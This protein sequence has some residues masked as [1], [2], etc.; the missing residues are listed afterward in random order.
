MQNSVSTRIAIAFGVLFAMGVATASAADPENA[1]P[2]DGPGRMMGSVMMGGGGA[3]MMS[4]CG[5]AHP[6][7]GGYG[8]MGMGGAGMMGHGGFGPM[9]MGGGMMGHGGYGMGRMGDF[10]MGPGMMMAYRMMYRLGLSDDQRA[11]VRKIMEQHHKQMWT[12][13]GDMMDARNKLRDLYD[14][15]QPDPAKVGAAF[16]EVSKFH[17][18]MLEARVRIR[19]EIGEV[20]TPEQREQ[21]GQWR[22]GAWRSGPR[23]SGGMG[24]GR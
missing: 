10:G 3:P 24:K 6:M 17:R 5:M 11:K 16:A 20:L 22:H 12:V 15:D 13:M 7:M 23:Q 1:R 8:S 4:G 21:L 18:Q 9:G 14:E 2:G 19:N